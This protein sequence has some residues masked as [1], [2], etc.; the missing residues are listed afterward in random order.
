MCRDNKVVK[1]NENV[2]R[3]QYAPLLYNAIGVE[4]GNDNGTEDGSSAINPCEPSVV[5]PPKLPLT[6][7]GNTGDDGSNGE[8]VP[9]NKG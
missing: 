8:S 2:K 9:T 6:D 4:K 5:E 3:E 7:E 1:N